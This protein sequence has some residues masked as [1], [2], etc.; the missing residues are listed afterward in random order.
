[1]NTCYRTTNKLAVSRTNPEHASTIQQFLT[2]FH[3]HEI[4]FMVHLHSIYSKYDTERTERI[5]AQLRSTFGFDHD[6]SDVA[7][8]L[9]FFSNRSRQPQAWHHLN[10]DQHLMTD[11]GAHY[12]E[13]YTTICPDCNEQLK[14]KDCTKMMIYIC[15]QRG[16]VL[17]GISC[18]M[19]SHM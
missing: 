16:K 7:A 5:T 17:P 19:T 6:I 8:L 4:T 18:K 13:P 15:Y 3:L 12:V 1:M 11:A 2:R 10:I 14:I 9:D